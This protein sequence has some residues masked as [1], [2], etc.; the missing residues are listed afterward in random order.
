MLFGLRNA[1]T[2][3]QALLLA[4][5]QKIAEVDWLKY[6]YSIAVIKLDTMFAG[7]V[8]TTSLY[9][10]QVPKMKKKIL[11]CIGGMKDLI[12]PFL[13]HPT[14][15]VKRFHRGTELV[16]HWDLYNL[17]KVI[18]P[19][20]ELTQPLTKRRGSAPSQ[21][22]ESVTSASN[23]PNKRTKRGTDAPTLMPATE[24]EKSSEMEK[25]LEEIRFSQANLLASKRAE[26][27]CNLT[28]NQMRESAT[29]LE[30][31]LQAAEEE[32]LQFQRELKVSNKIMSRFSRFSTGGEIDIVCLFCKGKRNERANHCE[33]C[34]TSSE[35]RIH[36]HR[37]RKA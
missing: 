3:F 22:S 20:A 15:A 1:N 2:P 28:I 27:S 37:P 30:A 8:Y 4:C 13:L 26:A 18:A 29:E 12:S 10:S 35:K 5:W 24:S 14:R 19:V 9:G 32:A 17:K 36:L 21:S 11:S 25:T 6:S 34:L 31:R 23:F 33:F 16:E 7:R